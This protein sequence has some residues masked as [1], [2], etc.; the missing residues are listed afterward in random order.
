MGCCGAAGEV[1][2]NDKT[3]ASKMPFATRQENIATLPDPEHMSTPE[4]PWPRT[5][6]ES[7]PVAAFGNR[8]RG[9]HKG[10]THASQERFQGGYQRLFHAAPDARSEMGNAVRAR[11]GFRISAP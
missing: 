11:P 7:I 4:D 6:R 1:G 3:T 9:K 8:E 10:D 5:P 2:I